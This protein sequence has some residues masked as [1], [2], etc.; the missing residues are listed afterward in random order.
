[1]ISYVVYR[2][3]IEYIY[4]YA[5]SVDWWQSFIVPQ[6]HIMLY[7]EVSQFLGEEQWPVGIGASNKNGATK[8]SDK[9]LQETAALPS[10]ALSKEVLY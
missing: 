1:M 5:Y 9:S 6:L 10:A 4:I 2:I 7:K 8:I 3:Y